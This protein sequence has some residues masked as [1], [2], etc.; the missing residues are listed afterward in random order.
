M[1]ILN[2][3]KPTI[4]GWPRI[5]AHSTVSWSHDQLSPPNRMLKGSSCLHV[6]L[7]LG[8]LAK[9]DWW[10]SHRHEK[11][12]NLCS[13]LGLESKLTLICLNMGYPISPMVNTVPHD[14]VGRYT[15]CPVFRRPGFESFEG[16]V[17]RSKPNFYGSLHNQV[18]PS[19]KNFRTK[20]WTCWNTYSYGPL[21]VMSTY[22]PIYR[23]YNPIE[24]TSYN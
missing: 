6:F 13:Y 1:N 12:T 5:L 22:N 11:Y 23:M 2:H 20:G 10:L 16:H 4:Q 14:F 17:Q 7:Q 21:P 3:T 8:Q 15:V 9:T 24:T 18:V 19:S